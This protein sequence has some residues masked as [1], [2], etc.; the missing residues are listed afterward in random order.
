MALAARPQLPA[1]PGQGRARLFDGG[2][3]LFRTLGGAEGKEYFRLGALE[4]SPDG[5]LAAV[6]VDE[7]GAERFTLRIRDIASGKDLETVTDVA[8]GQ[9]VWTSDSSG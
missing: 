8:I 7:S 9:P 5:R 2:E 1:G 3:R 4:V 6:L